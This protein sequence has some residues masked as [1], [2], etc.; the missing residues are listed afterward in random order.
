MY[1][2][3]PPLARSPTVAVANTD[4]TV[5]F[6]G[7]NAQPASPE[8][9]FPPHWAPMPRGAGWVLHC[10]DI[11]P[12]RVVKPLSQLRGREFNEPN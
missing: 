6:E 5:S 11:D 1:L 3:V 9:V 8:H 10:S 7:G 12:Q 4:E 2:I